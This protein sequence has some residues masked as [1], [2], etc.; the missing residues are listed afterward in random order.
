MPWM[1]E[2]KCVYK[3]VDGKKGELVKCYNTVDEAKA[4]LRAL[5]A[6]VT[7]SIQEFSMFI[8]KSSLNGEEMR[9]AAVN[10]DTSKDLYGV[11]S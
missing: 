3:E 4:H 6:N 1:I 8:T 2:G 10:S 5:Y 7:N 11:L 9:W